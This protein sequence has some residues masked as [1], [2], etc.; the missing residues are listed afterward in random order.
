[1]GRSGC[2]AV[3]RGQPTVNHNED[4]RKRIEGTLREQGNEKVLRSD[5]RIKERND[6]REEKRRRLAGGDQGNPA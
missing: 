2:R 5:E 3:N 6:E 1:M 4:C